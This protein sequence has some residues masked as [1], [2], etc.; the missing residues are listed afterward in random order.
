MT[1]TNWTYRNNYYYIIALYFISIS[2][3]CII[4]ANP[5]FF[6]HDDLDRYDSITQLGF[7]GFV[8]SL[9]IIKPGTTFGYPVRPFALFIQGLLSYFIRNYPVLVHLFAVVVQATVASLIFL[10]GRRI[11]SEPIKS[12]LWAVLFILSPLSLAGAGWS[13]ALMDQWYL[14]FGLLSLLSADK[15]IREN[16]TRS[17][18]IFIVFACSTLAILSKETA[19]VLPGLLLVY[20][21]IDHKRYL[22]K[23]FFVIAGAWCTPLVFYILFRFSAILTSLTTPV[24]DGYVTSITNLPINAFV[25]FSFPFLPFITEINTYI[26][27]PDYQLIVPF[28]F[29]LALVIGAAYYKSIKFAILYV[30]TYYLFLTPLLFITGVGSH[31]LYGSAVPLSLLMA[32]LT[33]DEDIPLY[34]RNISIC[35]LALLVIHLFVFQI[36]IY[37]DGTCQRRLMDSTESLYLS[38]G[39]PS[40]ISFQAM[41]GSPAHVLGRFAAKRNQIGIYYP[42][43]LKFSPWGEPLSEDSMNLLMDC[44]CFMIQQ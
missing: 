42:V 38:N 26:H 27:Y 18:H 8:K 7:T 35:A 11:V 13:A 36:S 34:F 9:L 32:I 14:L 15:A 20:L 22:S 44:D 17:I 16:D 31:Y 10:L 30:Y 23:R 12:F 19:I 29:H 33:T 6:T 37:K 1:R 25:Y 21:V 5:G 43:K 24:T 39:K 41:P 4:I 28:L 3:L 2:T 40:A